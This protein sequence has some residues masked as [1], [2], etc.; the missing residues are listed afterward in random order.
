MGTEK[1]NTDPEELARARAAHAL[2]GG[3]RIKRHIFLCAQSEKAACC[4]AEVGTPA[5]KFLKKELKA[6]GLD[7][8]GGIART[9]A[10][11]LK[12]CAAGPVAVV[13][14]DGVWYHSCTEPVLQRIIDE[15]L[16]GGVP[17]ECFRL[18]PEERQPE[19]P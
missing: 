10:D 9:K 5:W 17:V 8:D 14:P 19:E 7:R 6:R 4:S 1:V 2:N 13:W 3:D 15:H 11:C 16:V 18:Y 12:I